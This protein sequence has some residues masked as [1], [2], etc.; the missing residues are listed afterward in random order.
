MKISDR[1]EQISRHRLT[2]A[3]DAEGV[4]VNFHCGSFVRFRLNIDDRRSVCDVEFT[5]NGCGYMA[6]AAD[7]LAESLRN[8]LLADLGGLQQKMLSDRVIQLLSDFPADRRSCLD[9]VIESIKQ[10]FADLRRRVVTEYQ[11]ERALICTCFGVTQDRIEEAVRTG[12]LRSVDEV[13]AVTNAGRGCGSCRLL[14][15]EI[16]DGQT[17]NTTFGAPS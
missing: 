5:T 4:A 12:G 3:S 9:A 8:G 17:E 13:S 6:A 7:V 2:A 10:A 16:L 14:I 15:Q 1:L 11:G